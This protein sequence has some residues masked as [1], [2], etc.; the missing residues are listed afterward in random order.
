MAVI[1]APRLS[2]RCVPG[3]RSLVP[4][5]AQPRVR[6][7]VGSSARGCS[8]CPSGGASCRTRRCW[9]SAAVDDPLLLRPGV[10]LGGGV[11]LLNRARSS[12]PASEVASRCL[13]FGSEVSASSVSVVDVV[14][15]F[16]TAASVSFAGEVF[17]ICAADSRAGR[18]RQCW[19]R[20]LQ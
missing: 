11:G 18:S 4:P 14:F 5:T 9:F 6:L 10:A 7:R 17:F 15:V 1:V 13:S 12:A 20:R 8:S 19:C 3:R 16:C 2:L